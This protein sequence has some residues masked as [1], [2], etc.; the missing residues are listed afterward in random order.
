MY[1]ELFFKYTFNCV[2]SMLS[3]V[4]NRVFEKTAGVISAHRIILN[5]KTKLILDR[6]E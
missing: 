5:K 2:F 4:K 6:Y 3:G 1:T